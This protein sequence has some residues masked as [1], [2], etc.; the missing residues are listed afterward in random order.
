MTRPT[1]HRRPRPSGFTLIELLVVIAI[2]AVLIALLLPAVQAAREAARR[3]QCVN[4]LMQVIL[5]VKNYETSHEVLPPGSINPT[6][7]IANKPPG[8]HHNW[9]SQVLPFLE[10][11]NVSQHMNFNVS[12]YDPAN[13]S[14]RAV[15]LNSFVCP[16]DARVN[17]GPSILSNGPTVVSPSSYA[18]VHH[19]GEAPIDT[20]NHGVFFLNSRV[21]YEEIGDGSAQTI[22]IGEHL[23]SAD[24]GWASGTRSTLRNTGE[25]INQSRSA[26]LLV[27]PLPTTPPP[28]DA[29]DDDT[30]ADG[31]SAKPK[32]KAGAAGKPEKPA[33]PVGGFGSFHPGGANFAFGDGSVRFLKSTL[34]PEI[35]QL[36]ANRNDGEM[37]SGDKY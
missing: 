18:G 6:G 17:F 35:F 13:S 30:G 21:R 24:L 20:T 3:A 4:N 22:F 14:V 10:Y 2:I 1:A 31:P 23:I 25:Q 26:I 15:Q 28:S 12:V 19:D 9:I 7:P 33:D 16:S 5:A 27:T 8:Y 34:A 11:R 37:I 32:K 29:S 36:L